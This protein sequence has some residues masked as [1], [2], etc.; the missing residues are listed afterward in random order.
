MQK[1]ETI[2]FQWSN[3]CNR[4]TAFWYHYSTSRGLRLIGLHVSLSWKAKCATMRW[5]N[6]NMGSDVLPMVV[7]FSLCCCKLII[8]L[9][10]NGSTKS[11][12]DGFQSQLEKTD[13]H[14][15]EKAIFE[16][17]LRRQHILPRYCGIH[18]FSV[19]SDSHEQLFIRVI[20][21]HATGPWY[22]RRLRACVHIW[23]SILFLYLWVLSGKIFDLRFNSHGLQCSLR[24]GRVVPFP[25][26]NEILM[27]YSAL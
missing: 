24:M 2:L 12:Q 25:D 3:K 4:R 21:Q 23:M 9:L 17:L 20:G 11:N 16:S 6:A 22:S 19:R 10:A 13:P 18:E 27:S 1:K 8:E 26:L 7:A 14:C 15:Y 5:W